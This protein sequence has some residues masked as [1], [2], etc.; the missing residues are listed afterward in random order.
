MWQ[1]CG[2]ARS[3]GLR[4]PSE[5]FE[6]TLQPSTHRAE[7]PWPFVNLQLQ[8]GPLHLVFLAILQKHTATC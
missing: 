7:G 5:E 2:N 1:S 8:G 3:P 4:Q 6:V